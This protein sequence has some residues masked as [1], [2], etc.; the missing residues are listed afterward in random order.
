MFTRNAANFFSG[1]KRVETDR[2]GGFARIPYDWVGN[3]ARGASTIA[4]STD[5]KN[6]RDYNHRRYDCLY[7]PVAICNTLRGRTQSWAQC[8]HL[9]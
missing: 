3:W 5:A 6:Q 7:K 9:L 1:D 2:A 8:G 4:L